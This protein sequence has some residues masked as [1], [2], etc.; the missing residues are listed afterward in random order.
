MRNCRRFRWTTKNPKVT[1]GLS[2]GV[3]DMNDPPERR[4]SYGAARLELSGLMFLVMEPPDPPYPCKD[5][6]GLTL[7]GC[8]MSKNLDNALL[9]SLPEGVF[10]RS[11]WVNEWNAF[12]HIAAKDAEIVWQSEEVYRPRRELRAKS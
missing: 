11:L 5:S 7:N 12:L 8:D 9:K 4:E 1:L 6:A 3:G 10:V 2:V